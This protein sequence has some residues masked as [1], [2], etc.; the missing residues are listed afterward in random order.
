MKC[1]FCHARM[2]RVLSSVNRVEFECKRCGACLIVKQNEVTW[3]VPEDI[4][5][6]IDSVKAESFPTAQ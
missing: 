1:N 2:E 4:S 6:I 3:R 5:K